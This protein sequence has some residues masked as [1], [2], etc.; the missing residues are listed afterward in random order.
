MT[1]TYRFLEAS[2]WLNDKDVRN[3]CRAVHTTIPLLEERLTVETC[4]NIR[5]AEDAG[6]VFPDMLPT[7]GLAPAKNYSFISVRLNLM[8]T[9]NLCWVQDLKTSC[10]HET[11]H[12][13]QF[14]AG[15]QVQNFTLPSDLIMEG[16][17]QCFEVEMGLPRARSS[18]VLKTKAEWDLATREAVKVLNGEKAYHRPNWLYGKSE[19]YLDDR[20]YTI[21][22]LDQLAY[23]YM[24]EQ[25]YEPIIHK[26]R[27]AYAL[28][29]A[30]VSGYCNQEK[31]LPSKLI[32]TQ[33]EVIINEWLDG[34]IKLAPE[35]PN[36]D[37]MRRRA[38]ELG[39]SSKPID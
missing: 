39:Y 16:F 11:F 32:A 31:E 4:L 13:A 12:N 17:A 1:I 20:S 15:Y 34:K 30:I 38:N 3:I 19:R 28:G 22:P 26:R 10:V 37:M 21:G 27:T 2:R 24:S 5:Q 8:D 6:L 36:R 35:G 23:Y 33:P 7:I 14:Q 29:F 25:G 9:S 18:M